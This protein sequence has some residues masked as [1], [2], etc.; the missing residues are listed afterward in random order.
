MLPAQETQRTSDAVTFRPRTINSS[1]SEP[2]TYATVDA[3]SENFPDEGDPSEAAATDG[4]SL[5]SSHAVSASE[6]P[7]NDRARA[8]ETIKSHT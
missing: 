6:N 5:E 2:P 3:H 8:M 1:V 4:T 7:F